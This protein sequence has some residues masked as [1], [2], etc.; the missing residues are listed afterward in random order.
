MR[1]FTWSMRFAIAISTVFAFAALVAGGVSYTLQS[2]EMSRRLEGEVR[3]DTEALALSA[4]GADLQDLSEQISARM[5]TSRDGANIVTFVPADGSEP[6]GNVRV[7]TQFEGARHLEP[8]PDVTLLD[9]PGANVPEGYVTFGMRLPSGWLMTGR[10]DAWLREQGEILATSF[11]WG[12]GLALLLSISFAVFIARRNEVRIDRMEQVLHAVGEGRHGLRIR[13]EGDD[14]VARLAQSVDQAL[15][16]LEA[17]IASIRQVSTDVAHDL[18]APLARLRLRLEPVALDSSLPLAQRGEIGKALSDLDQ[19]SETFDAIL[20]LSRM[21]AGMVEI[22]RA[23]IDL[24]QLCQD[25]AEM[26]G[27][28][29]EDAGQ[30]LALDLPD[31]VRIEG[32]RE[33][34]FQALVN[35]V[36]NAL[37]YSPSPAR[38]SIGVHETRHHITLSV[39]DNGPGIPDRDLARVRERFVRLDRSR[40]TQGSGLGLSLVDAI[41]QIH[42]GELRLQNLERGLRVDIRFPKP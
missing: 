19:V 20:R 6:L 4:R 17:G 42:G 13:D 16:Q 15:D 41:A 34:L 23:S 5:T 22:T 37:R 10:D 1:A 39:T 27:A 12:L 9:P 38:V 32:D 3:A 11:G 31:D 2:K 36:D 14:D 30:E 18:R 21:Q 24:T 33:L 35:L 25:V 28:G 29:A 40:N 8:G 26:L 7:A